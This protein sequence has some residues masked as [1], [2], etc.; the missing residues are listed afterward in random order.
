M[1]FNCA[2]TAGHGSLLLRNTAAEKI[3]HIQQRMSAFRSAELQR[4]DAHPQTLTIGD[5]TT[6]N[7]T[8]LAG[9]VQSNVVPPLMA[10]TYDV[11]LAVDVAPEAFEAQLREWCAEAER[12]AGG[13]GGDPDGSVELE[14]LMKEPFVAPMERGEANAFWQAFKAVVCG[15]L[16]LRIREVV[17][18]GATDSRFVRAAGIQAIGFSPIDRTPVLLHDHDEWLGAATYVRGV[19][20]YAKLVE[21]LANL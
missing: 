2:G 19:E 10:L 13:G 20:I 5:V 21:K 4:L 3:L 9:G 18:P 1:R 8:M 7:L 12:A 17:F 15:E 14:F 11:R 16:G 6:V